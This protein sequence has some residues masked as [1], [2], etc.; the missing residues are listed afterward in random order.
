MTSDEPRVGLRAIRPSQYIFGIQAI[1]LLAS[2][3]YTLLW[4]GAVANMPDSPLEGVSSGA[5]QAMSLTSMALG[6]CQTIAA[7]QNNIPIMIAAVP[8]RLLAAFVFHRSGGGWRKLAPFEGCM[9]LLVAIGVYWTW[10]TDRGS[11]D[12]DKDRSKDN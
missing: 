6:T 5:I 9:G 1:P 11:R 7:Y 3:V 4:P 10:Y 12:G 2:G 8:G